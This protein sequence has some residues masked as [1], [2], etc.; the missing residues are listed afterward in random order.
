MDE[1]NDPTEKLLREIVAAY[2]ATQNHPLEAKDH[3][4]HLRYQVA[5]LARV[6]IELNH[7]IKQLEAHPGPNPKPPEKT[8]K[9]KEEDLGGRITAL[10][11]IW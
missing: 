5:R 11:D 3:I 6:C 7:R 1:H 10:G 2:K 9:D 8:N 4:K